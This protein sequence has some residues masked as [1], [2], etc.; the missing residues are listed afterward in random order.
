M[1]AVRLRQLVRSEIVSSIGAF[2]HS[3]GTG[4]LEVITA[5][6]RKSRVDAEASRNQGKLGS[7]GRMKEALVTMQFATENTQH[8]L[9]RECETSRAEVGAAK[10]KSRPPEQRSRPAKLKSRPSEQK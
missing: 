8:Q 10:Q 5:E 3:H 9:E 6:V 2:Q 1:R 4:P 7:V